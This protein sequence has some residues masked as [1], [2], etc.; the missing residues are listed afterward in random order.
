MLDS[1]KCWVKCMRIIGIDIGGTTVKLG[2]VEQG[3][4]IVYREE[5][6]TV[7]NPDGM[8]DCVWQMVERARQKYPAD[9][10]AVSIAGSI[11][12]MGRVTAN[13]LGFMDAPIKTLL[14]E[15]INERVLIENDGICAIEAEHK[16]GVL[17]GYD[18]ALMLTLGTGIGGGAIVF[19]RPCRGRKGAHAELGHMIT[20]VGGKYCSCGQRGCWECYA[21]ASALSQMAGG[22][23]PKKVLDLVKQEQ[24]QEV[25]KEYL[26][27][28]TQGM[29]GLFSIFY[30]D[31][32]AIGGGLSN[33]GSFFIEEINKALQQE[34]SY[35]AYHSNVRVLTAHFNN[36]AGIIGAAALALLEEGQ[37]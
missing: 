7:H 18:S 9:K 23:S 4:D 14:E 30:P 1:T 11:D 28:L 8:T 5:A 26:Y 21:S 27:E 29:I 24:L 31:A 10:V 22:F 36:D 25:W 16:M 19:G 3:K 35:R 20:H 34:A 12:S 32:V 13:Q 2:V 17:K 37:K 6:A 33:A 15:K